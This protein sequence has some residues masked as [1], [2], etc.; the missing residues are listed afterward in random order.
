MERNTIKSWL[1]TSMF[2]MAVFVLYPASVVKAS[3]YNLWVGNTHVTSDNAQDILGDGTASFDA[4]SNKL[5]LNNANITT[6]YIYDDYVSCGIYTTMDTLLITGDGTINISQNI[7]PN[8]S[9][10]GIVMNRPNGSLSVEGTGNGISIQAT[11][12]G[13]TTILPE[14]DGGTLNLSGNIAVDVNGPSSYGI[15]SNGTV[16]IKNGMVKAIGFKE[17]IY[18]KEISIGGEVTKVQAEITTGNGIGSY[19]FALRGLNSLLINPALSIT[20]PQG[21]Y[22]GT[23]GNGKMILAQDGSDPT[24]IVIE[25]SSENDNGNNNA[26]NSETTNNETTKPATIP[27]FKLNTSSVVIQKG[28]TLK[29]V[30]ATLTNDEIKSVESANSK[31]ATVSY[32]GT[33]LSIKGIKK[34]ST[35]ITVT[36]KSGLSCK[37]NVKVQTG[38][39]TTTKLKVSKKSVNL[40]SKGSIATVKAT[41]SPDYVSTKEKITVKSSN[42]KIATAKIDQETGEITITAKKKGSCKITVKAGKKTV[43]IKV[44]VKK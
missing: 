35:K 37:L 7:L 27:S 6:G 36:T 24:K 2:A 40:A 34:G 17:G 9:T 28:K 20:T 38:K 3:V 42:K 32:S 22:I 31:I 41:A 29:T 18:G 14:Y 30:K 15:H 23:S 8:G 44:K 13:I 21:G 4:D 16:N 19:A 33:T 25:R 39:V 1:I 43:T 26:D 12:Y 10:A 5:I 11:S